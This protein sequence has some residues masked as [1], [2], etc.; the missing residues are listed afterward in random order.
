MR[1]RGARAMSWELWLP[2]LVMYVIA[3]LALIK[4]SFRHMGPRLLWAAWLWPLSMIQAF[5]EEL[6]S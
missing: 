2:P 4:I 6:R 1:H 5:I 3:T